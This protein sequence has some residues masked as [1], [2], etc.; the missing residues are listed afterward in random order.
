MVEAKPINTTGDQDGDVT[1]DTAVTEDQLTVKDSELEI[2]IKF[3][4]ETCQSLLAVNKDLLNRELHSPDQKELLTQFAIAGT[5]RTLVAVK[6]ERQ[7]GVEV[8]SSSAAGSK[9]NDDSNTDSQ[10]LSRLENEQVDVIFSS[11][12]EYH[13]NK[14]QSIGFIKRDTGK[15]DL[16]SD[17]DLDKALDAALNS[18]SEAPDAGDHTDLCQ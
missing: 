11:K 18:E 12:I 1:Q 9:S 13:G 17:I 8:D 16:R 3:L 2:L 5:V 14:A 10:S 15:L 4:I 7:G 6:V